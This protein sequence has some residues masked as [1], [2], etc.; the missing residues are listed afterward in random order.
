MA[1]DI[2]LDPPNELIDTPCMPG[3]LINTSCLPSTADSR[4][5]SI[6]TLTSWQLLAKQVGT[7]GSDDNDDDEAPPASTSKIPQAVAAELQCSPRSVSWTSG[8]HR[9]A[10][11]PHANLYKEYR[12]LET[13]GKG[14]FGTVSLAVRRAD[15]KQLVA[16]EIANGQASLATPRQREAIMDEASPAAPWSGP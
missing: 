9:I 3:D 1:D 12:L 16:K 2:E 15:G 6:G 7:G 11:R 14:A 10:P 5:N 4:C 8:L 13:I